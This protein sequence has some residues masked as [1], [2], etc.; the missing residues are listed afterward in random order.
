[1]LNRKYRT[2]S[3][4]FFSKINKNFV[5][6]FCFII[7]ASLSVIVALGLNIKWQIHNFCECVFIV[8]IFI[9]FMY[10]K[11]CLLLYVWIRKP[12]LFSVTLVNVVEYC[13]SSSFQNP[14]SLYIKIM[15]IHTSYEFLTFVR[16][17]VNLT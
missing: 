15:N 17:F 12:L 2:F 16:Y 13:I 8:Y 5:I 7:H 11:V 10:V 6:V 14:L 1:M 9:I 3:E 4:K